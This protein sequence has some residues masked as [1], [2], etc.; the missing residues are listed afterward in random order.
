M[1][2]TSRS[3]SI[4]LTFLGHSCL[5]VDVSR[6]HH[7]A[8]RLLIDP[9][10][11]TPPLDA[12]DGV[13]SVLISHAHPDHID[14]AQIDR[15]GRG[16]GFQIFGD[17]NTTEV[18][19]KS[20]F[21]ATF[22]E[23]GSFELEGFEITAIAAEHMPI[24]HQSVPLPGNLAFFLGRRIFAPGDSMIVPNWQ[25]EVLL[26]PIGGPWMKLQESIDYLRAVAPRYAIPIH[27]AG[28]APAHQ[29][30]HRALIGKFTPE[31]TTIVNLKI[32]QQFTL[33]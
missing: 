20:G 7:D 11:L 8:L 27:D 2:N 18:L 6:Q 29:D 22:I 9:G 10:N 12:I 1:N 32:G 16:K 13:A 24:Y 21:E 4:T 31:N 26:L 17:A 25:V 19:A 28:L 15:L 30:L 33:I 3:E 23:P 5:T 14:A